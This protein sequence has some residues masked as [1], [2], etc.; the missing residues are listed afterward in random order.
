MLSLGRPTLK[1]TIACCFISVSASD[2]KMCNR[3]N[4]SIPSGRERRW[5]QTS[6]IKTFQADRFFRRFAL[7]DDVTTG[8]KNQTPPLFYRK[9]TEPLYHSFMHSLVSSFFPVS[10]SRKGPVAI[11]GMQIPA[12]FDKCPVSFGR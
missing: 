3:E 1:N 8:L 2:T 4:A 7:N 10:M 11:M 9:D 6:R 5:S 12:K